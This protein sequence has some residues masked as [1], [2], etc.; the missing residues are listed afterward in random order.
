MTGCY[1]ILTQAGIPLSRYNI[2]FVQQTNALF[3]ND[4]FKALNDRLTI[5]AGF[6]EAMVSRMSTQLIRGANY[7]STV[8]YA[9][10]LPQF[11]ASYRLT[12]RSTSMDQQASGHRP[13]C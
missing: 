10:P 3:I 11:A 2:N 1:S 4:T 12:T 13:Q 5:E 9:E 8:N 6:K 7:K